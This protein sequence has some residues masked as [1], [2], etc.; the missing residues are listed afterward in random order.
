MVR[1]RAATLV[2]ATREIDLSHAT[3]MREM[4]QRKTK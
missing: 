2:T 4:L 1:G 3:V